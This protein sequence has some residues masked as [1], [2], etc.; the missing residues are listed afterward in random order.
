VDGLVAVCLFALVAVQLDDPAPAGAR[1]GDPLAY[2]LAAALA[3]SYLLH[4]RWPLQALTATLAA[5]LLYSADHYVGY[6]GFAVFATVFGLALHASRRQA[7]IGYAASLVALSVALAMQPAALVTTSDWFSSLLVLTVAFLAGEN[8]RAR[9]ARWSAL[10]ERNLRLELE[11]E[12]RAR[13]AVEEERMRIARELHDVVAHSMSVIAVQAGVA[14]HVI[15]SRPELA[16]QAL[17]TIETTARSGLVELRR[18]LGVL[19]QPDEPGGDLTPAPGLGDLAELR[20]GLAE[21]GLEVSLTVGGD[22]ERVPPGAQLSAYRI[23]QEA[24]TNVLKYGGPSAAVHVAASP[25]A[26][27]VEV[28]DPGRG[29]GPGET[30]PGAGQ[31]LV[32]MRERVAVFG[33]TLEAGP[34]PEGGFRVRAVL[35]CSS[36]A[37]TE[38]VPPDVRAGRGEPA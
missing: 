12:E 37:L 35:P 14:H 36:D 38:G 9:R 34:T 10:E 11:R 15:G 23:V 4:R 8:L 3:A 32:G 1:T 27:V 18:M 24:L 26:V 5:L 33:G 2:L 13:Q 28:V 31:G 22:A 7:A 17:A 19:R 25:S 16:E 21:A 30:V 6:P 20:D 29:S